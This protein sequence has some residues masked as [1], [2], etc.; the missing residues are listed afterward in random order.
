[1]P[2]S[3]VS[4]GAALLGS[5]SQSLWD[6][7]DALV[8]RAP[9][10]SDLASH[11]IE[12]LAAR[13]WRA[14]GKPVPAGLVAEERAGRVSA[15]TVVPTLQRVR[16][17]YDGRIL[18]LKGPEAAAHYPDPALRSFKDLDLLVAEPG[19]A[20]R[21]LLG[22]GF[23][24][25]GDPDL[26]IGIH[27][28]RP[29]AAPG[30]PLAIELHSQPKWVDGL[31]RPSTDELF[32]AAVGSVVA[33]DGVEALPPAHHGLVLAAHSWAHE[34]LRRLRDLVDIAAVVGA[35]G[36]DEVE[37]L[38][39]RWGLRRLWRTT[40]AATDALFA[41]GPTPWAFR[42]W[43]QNVSKVRER[44]VIENHAQAWLSSFWVLQPQEAARALGR[45]LAAEVRPQRGE[46]WAAKGRRARMATRHAFDRRSDH[47]R[48]L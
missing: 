26:Y 6:A 5:T 8:D 48:T 4:A 42:L 25:I 37:A 22:A 1:V 7:V 45:S 12:L 11:R 16:E 3:G 46:R 23:E 35:T 47:E 27:H 30:L 33:V 34:P 43:A 28:L 19:K 31:P 40:A 44:T 29:L 24:P 38:A 17:A 2:L 13:R 9:R 18:L 15:L 36:P 41:G 39:E 21:A 20:W 10:E 14:Q 32:D